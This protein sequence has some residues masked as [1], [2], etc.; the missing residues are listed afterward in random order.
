[1]LR[2]TC[3]SIAI[4]ALAAAC[5][6]Q[7]DRWVFEDF[8]SVEH[9]TGAELGTEVARHGETSALWRNHPDTSSISSENIPHDWTDWSAFTFWVYNEREVDTAF[10]CIISS[11]NPETDGIDYWSVRVPLN[12]TGWRIFGVEIR[13]G[14]G[15][16]QPR[17]WD[18]VDSIRFTAAGWGHEPH[19][20]A[21]V[22]IDQ[23]ELR[24]DVAGEGPLLD[25][26][27]FFSLL[28]DDIEGLAA[29]REAAERGDYDLAAEHL[30]EYYRGRDWPT[31]NFDPS[32]YDQHREEDYNTSRADYVLTRMFDRFGREA[33]VGDPIDWSFNGFDPDEP[34]YTP[35]WTYQLNRFQNWRILGQAWW[36][37]GDDRYA[38]EFVE[39]MLSWIHSEPTPVFGSPNRAP[40]WRTIEQGIRTA[41]SWMDAYHYFL[42]APQM[43]P[44]AHLTFLKSWVEHARALTRMTVEYTER[45]SNWVA[46]ECN[47]LAHIGCMFPEFTEAEHWRDVAYER[48]LIE[49][50]EQVYPDGAQLELAPSYHMVSLGNFRRATLPAIRN[51]FELPDGYIDGMRRMY[52]YNLKI[53]MPTGQMP[54]LNDSGMSRVQASLQE[55][56]ETWGDP[57]YLWGATLGAEGEPV[58]YLSTFLPWAGWAVMRSDWWAE[59]ALYMIYQ[60]GPFGIAHQH[61]DKLSMYLWGYGRTLL[62]EGGNYSY[63]RS[64]WRRFVLDTP[65]HNTVMVDGMSQRRRGLRE[66]YQTDEP[67]EGVWATNELFDWCIGTYE[68]GYGEDRM[69]VTHERSLIF[70]RPDYYVVIDRMLDA[71][72][73]HLYEAL[74]NLDAEEAAVHDDGLSVSSA[75]EGRAN[76]TL[77]P[78]ATEGLS[79]RIAKGQED[80]LLGWEPRTGHHRPIPCVVYSK[81]GPT[82][83]TLVTLMFPHPTEEPPAV[84][85]EVLLQTDQMIAIRVSRE[86]GEETILYSFD[87]P[88]QMEA[89]GVSAHARLAV[90]R[91]DAEG[92]V[93]GGMVEGTG[94][95]V[96]GEAVEMQ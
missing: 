16:R 10:M 65:A 77:I 4:V 27:E 57:E 91:R 53:A 94:L 42:F 44:E 76:L 61:E 71:E 51:G 28:R 54:P 45:R 87:R 1:M 79:M 26:E 80:P 82:P 18:Q 29:T 30:L 23:L 25:D 3:V 73:D 64:E 47:G 46:M 75:D 22:Y 62:T 32:E 9:W 96:D 70:V 13:E 15:I 86:E 52:D 33:Y 37:T 90:I 8:S 41:G 2:I 78:L 7:N 12:F 35:E 72:G 92:A 83:E 48:L 19:P 20:E 84:E 50:D 63:D 36:A 40:T 24:N 88:A 81:Q 11:N 85:A 68:E 31:W 93:S 58:D 66:T 74:F 60:V 89:G 17:G 56:Y 21:V 38:E 49:I 6:A 34:A 67:L 59:D 14:T 69:P 95:T 39:Q 43:T 55:A 5:H